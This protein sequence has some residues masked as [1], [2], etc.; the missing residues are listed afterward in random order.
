MNREWVNEYADPQIA[1]YFEAPKIKMNEEKCSLNSLKHTHAHR[2][3]RKVKNVTR[4]KKKFEPRTRIYVPVSNGILACVFFHF[5]RVHFSF[6]C[7][8]SIFS[9]TIVASYHQPSCGSSGNETRNISF[10][11]QFIRSFVRSSVLVCHSCVHIHTEQMIGEVYKCLNAIHIK[12]SMQCWSMYEY[13]QKTT[14]W[15]CVTTH[16]CWFWYSYRFTSQYIVF[17]SFLAAVDG[18]WL[19]RIT[20]VLPSIKKTESFYFRI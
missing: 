2:W 17:T 4:D 18:W 9:G 1:I 8:S 10:A 15:P 13:A 3:R 6:Y 19:M 16:Q 11:L 20:V 5:F 14:A 12:C 7:F